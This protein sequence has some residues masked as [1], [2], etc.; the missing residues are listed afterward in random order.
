MTTLPFKLSV[1]PAPS[2]FLLTVRGPMAPKTLDEGRKAH[3]LAAG[4][5]QGVAAARSFGDLSHAVFVPVQPNGS[6]AGE[7][8]IIDYWNSV[9]GLQTFFAQLPEQTAETTLYRDREAVVWAPSPG[10]PRF[11]LPAPTGR[12]E[13]WVGIARGPVASRRCRRQAPDRDDAEA[14]QHR[15]GQGADVAGMVPPAR[16]AGRRNAAGDHR[17][18]HLVRCRRHAGG[19]L[20]PGRDDRLRRPF[21]R[22]AADLGV[23]EARGPLGRV[24]DEAPRVALAIPAAPYHVTA[25]PGGSEGWRWRRNRIAAGERHWSPAAIAGWAWRPAASFIRDGY[26]VILTARDAA[27]GEASAKAIGAAFR[28]LDV[29]DA[30]SIAAL[31]AGLAADGVTVDI[32][33]NNAAV[34]L[35][36]FNAEVARKTIDANVYGPLR[37]TDARAAAHA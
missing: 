34:A 25:R 28:P 2:Q 23:E 8:L 32:L 6:G 22:A 7:L 24:V 35:D 12:D 18:R 13:R 16:P 3:N 17:R 19:L 5:D 26:R 14:G 21:H 4:S 20:R 37:V 10:L 11:S 9:E 29:T 36:G 31:A 33:V 27:G 1:D 30:T 15:A